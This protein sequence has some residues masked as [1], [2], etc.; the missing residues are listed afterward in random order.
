VFK[1][2]FNKLE[3]LLTHNQMDKKKLQAEHKLVLQHS[4]DE[5]D[6]KVKVL[7]MKFQAI[8]QHHI[9]TKPKEKM[10]AVVQTEQ[11][12]LK[13]PTLCK[14]VLTQTSPQSVFDESTQIDMFHADTCDMNV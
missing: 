4:I 8:E 5:M 11:V 10:H 14:E 6:S 3:V 13:R 9:M 7:N 2:L 12:D 1:N